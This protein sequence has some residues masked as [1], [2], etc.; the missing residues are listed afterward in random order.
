MV[1]SYSRY[2]HSA[3]FGV[4][5]SSS[6]V[7]YMPQQSGR[8]LSSGLEDILLW[9]IKTGELVQ[10]LRDGVDVGA[11]NS[12]T[13]TAPAIV[14]YLQYH[15]QTNIAAA[16]Y[17]DGSIKIWDLSSS[18]VLIVFTGHKSAITHLMFDNSGTRLCSG[19]KDSNII[20]WDL[21]GEVGLFKLKGHKD[22]ITGFS[23]ASDNNNADIDEM[24]E[25]LISTSKDGLIKLWDLKS[26]ICVE[27]H[28]AHS[29]ECW[30]FDYDP[31]SQVLITSGME[32]QLKVWFVNLESEDSKLI[33]KG[34]YLKQSNSRATNIEF[35]Y[36]SSKLIFFMCQNSDKTIELF[37]IRTSEEVDKAISRK[38]KKLSEKGNYTEEEINE[39][40]ESGKINMLI[41]PIT[42]IRSLAKIKSSTWGSC[43]SKGLEILISA[44]NNSIEYYHV[45]LPAQVRKISITNNEIQPVKKHAVDL[46]GHRTDIRSM[47]ISHDDKLLATA[48]NGELKIWNIKTK[49]CL[50]TITCGYSICCQFLPGDGLVVIGTRSGDLQLFDLASSELVSEI[51]EAHDSAIWSLD[52]TED[53]KTL[54]T[55]SADK[56]IKFWNFKV[57]EET[58][59]GSNST[60]RKLKMVHSKTLELDEDILSIKISRD[61]KYLAVSL[62]D[63]TVKVF[64]FATLKFY[65]SL[66]GHKLP[67]LS[68]DI[69][70]DSKLIVTSSADKNIKIWGL[71]FGDCHKSIFAHQDSIM[72]VKFLPESHNFFSTSKDGMVKYWDGDKFE[73]IQKLAAHQS[74][75]WALV[76]AYSGE[77]VITA[78]HD[79]SIRIWEET[80]DQVFIE[81]EK[82]KEI[83]E[84]YEQ[85]L[86][87]S[88][89]NDDIV[90]R[91]SEDDND[92]VEGVNKQTIESLKDGEKLMEALD[93]GIE[94]IEKQQDYESKLNGHK[95]GL[96][97]VPIK[98]DRHIMLLAKNVSAQEYVFQVTKNI[99]AS[100]LEDAILV[101]PFS[102]SVKLLKFLDYWTSEKK[103]LLNNLS[104]V[105][106]LLFFIIRIHHKELISTKDS[107]IKR[108]LTDVKDK[109][110]N[111][112]KSINDDLGYN[113]QGLKFI[114]T[115][116][117]LKHSKEFVD[118]YKQTSTEDKF[119]KKR[120]FE[121]VI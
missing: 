68:I 81:E 110:R 53:G 43:T 16:G 27:T 21:V 114:K 99:K 7:V 17:S 106:R 6:N 12:K 87:E 11:S 60:F 111:E 115:Q 26:K 18:S 71:D 78:S 15:E 94:D 30:S 107:A 72:N 92:E 121:K 75:V 4:I 56:S 67:V 117:A 35:K 52:L 62:L 42:V 19:S 89:E 105:C 49:N 5:S 59:P 54:V 46:L 119:S 116:W 28:V 118:E 2:E 79:H 95:N 109:L 96:N 76:I 98:P 22:Q 23:F 34:I 83:E 73:C 70:F 69:S 84:L 93:I 63:N 65:L 20:M 91:N 45:N 86:L 48:S 90:P 33:E 101:L 108:R 57:E 38:I 50:R 37:R 3:S 10:K 25:W 97:D 39:Q 9:N 61:N 13:L 14:T 40:I 32:N 31:K 64:H 24:E 8:A 104:L 29:G 113:I 44:N 41:H 82:E 77:F 47:A 103:Y 66:Y 36:L 80:S 55:G 1:K 120:V 102:Y 85:T 51:T 100:H 112:M 88:L 58:V 74:E